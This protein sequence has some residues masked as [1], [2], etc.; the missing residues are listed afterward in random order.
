MSQSPRLPYGSPTT[1]SGIS[2]NFALHSSLES[3][4]TARTLAFQKAHP[5]LADARSPI[6]AKV[7]NRDIAILSSYDHVQKIL[8][9]ETIASFV[10]SGQA[11]NELMAPFFP[12]PNLLLLDPPDHQRRKEVWLERMRSLNVDVRTAVRRCVCDHFGSIPPGSVVDLYE[13]MKSLSWRILL[14]IFLQNEMNGY[15]GDDA[16]KVEALHED[17][18]RGQFSLFPISIST[19]FWRSPRSTGLQARQQLQSILRSKVSRGKC[20]FAVSNPEEEQDIAD[21]LLL[22]TSSLAAKSIAS[23]LMAVLLDIFLFNEAGTSLSAKIRNIADAKQRDIYIQSMISEVERLSPPVVG[24]M[25]RATK[26]IVLNSREETIPPTLVPKGWD[27][28]LY[29]LGAGR[30]PAAFG[31]T[32]E[33]F[34]PSRYLD[35]PALQQE[36]LAFGAG[37]KTCLGKDL[38][39]RVVMAVVETCLEQAPIPE[40]TGGPMI[41]LQS[42]G[43]ELAAGLQGWLGWK[44]KVKPEDWARHMKQ[45]PTQR[46]RRPI[47]VKVLH[48]LAT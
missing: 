13:S 44:P 35:A 45:L 14:S 31:E 47:M 16:S 5:H 30:D 24:I 6:R 40:P 43:N 7:L 17:L 27:I 28:W 4:I 32:A 23:L 48:Q 2:E 11:Y 15:S 12:P 1:L 9:N 36:G 37:A 22:F 33:N 26:D 20:P 8:C 38:I 46:P 39:R 34:V 21:H 29:F 19:P 42:D 10:S 18:L 25:R 3:F 41:E